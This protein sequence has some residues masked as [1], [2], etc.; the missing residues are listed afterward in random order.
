MKNIGVPLVRYLRKV[1]FVTMNSVEKK[2]EGS[3]PQKGDQSLLTTKEERSKIM[4]IVECSDCDGTGE[5][6]CE[7]CS[8]DEDCDECLEFRVIDCY[9]CGASGEIDGGPDC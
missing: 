9:F 5:L 7:E 1:K 2:R 6:E 3:F 8:E 4:T